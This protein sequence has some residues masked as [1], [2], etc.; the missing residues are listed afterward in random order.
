MIQLGD[1][2]WE[3]IRHHFPEEHIP[4]GRPGRKPI[5]TRRVLEAVLWILNTGAQWHMSSSFAR[6]S[7]CQC[8]YDDFPAR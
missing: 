3:R 6:R 1:E 4:D 8:H 5:P 2:Q 7:S